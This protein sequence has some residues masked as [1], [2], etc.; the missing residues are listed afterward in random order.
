MRKYSLYRK[1]K[2]LRLAVAA[3]FANYILLKRTL[4]FWHDRLKST[5]ETIRMC[6]EITRHRHSLEK[7]LTLSSLKQSTLKYIYAVHHHRM[8]VFKKYF[9][10][11][12]RRSNCDWFKLRF[13]RWRYESK[14]ILFSDEN[15]DFF[16]SDFSTWIFIEGKI[17]QRNFFISHANEE[18]F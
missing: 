7:F 11:L 1:V 5:K 17:L 16:V 6:L 12:K 8:K 18:E 14:I 9:C 4:K 10:K 13:W 3:S 2:K 15:L